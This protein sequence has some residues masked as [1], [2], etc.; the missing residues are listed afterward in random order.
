MKQSLCLRVNTKTHILVS[1]VNDS[2]F[3][4]TAAVVIACKSGCAFSNT[5]LVSVQKSER[6]II[7]VLS[8]VIV[9]I[10]V[11]FWTF[12]D[13]CWSVTCSKIQKSFLNLWGL[14]IHLR[15]TRC[16]FGRYIWSNLKFSFVFNCVPRRGRASVGP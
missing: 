1:G 14:Q 13:A 11:A 12:L 5:G 8:N 10:H 3:F 16:F 4:Y 2:L 15:E 7:L 9:F 6:Q